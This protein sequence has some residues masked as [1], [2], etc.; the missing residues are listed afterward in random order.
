VAVHEKVTNDSQSSVCLHFETDIRIPS[1]R[2]DSAFP[3]A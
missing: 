3:T 2:N 1:G